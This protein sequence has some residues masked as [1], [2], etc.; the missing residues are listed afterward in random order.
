MGKMCRSP[1]RLPRTIPQGASST[2][3]RWGVC[4]GFACEGGLGLVVGWSVDRGWG[5]QAVP[6][7]ALPLGL[8]WKP[9]PP[10]RSSKDIKPPPLI[11]Q[12]CLPLLHSMAADKT[13]NAA[14]G[15]RWSCCRR[16]P[17]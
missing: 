4:W 1:G 3:F 2:S 12:H 17:M 8:P 7:A 16:S 13:S 6:R 10:P 14:T 9:P 5:L 15:Q 11:F